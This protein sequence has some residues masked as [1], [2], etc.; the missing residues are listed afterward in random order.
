MSFWKAHDYVKNPIL[1]VIHRIIFNNIWRI[2]FL[3][4]ILVVSSLIPFDWSFYPMIGSAIILAIHVP[5][6]LIIGATYKKGK[7]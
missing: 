4:I 7:K 6:A 3:F 1:R 5:V 2:G